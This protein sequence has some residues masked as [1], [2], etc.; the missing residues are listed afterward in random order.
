MLE[1]LW[2]NKY[3]NALLAE[4]WTGLAILQNNLK[5]CPK[6]IKLCIFFDL[7]IPLL[8]LYPKESKEK[9]PLYTKLLIAAPFVAAKNWKLRECWTTAERL[10]KLWY[11]IWNTSILLGWKGQFEMSEKICMNWCWMRWAEPGEQLV[12]QLH[13]NHPH[14]QKTHNKTRCLPPNRELMD[15]EQMTYFLFGHGQSRNLFCSIK[16][17]CNRFFFFLLSQ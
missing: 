13:N 1:E 11:M 5:L 6:V 8:G 7:V 2:K 3:I 15:S 4:L 14:F 17:V 12:E 10:N 9:R 16:H